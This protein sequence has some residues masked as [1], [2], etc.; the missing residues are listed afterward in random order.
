MRRE[1]EGGILYKALI[2][3]NDVRSIDN[4]YNAF[5]WK[6]LY[7]NEVIK[8]SNTCNLTQIIQKENP[9]IVMIDIEMGDVSG[10]DVIETCRKTGNKALFVIISGHCDFYCAKTAIKLDV[11]YFVS[12]PIMKWDVEEATIKIADKLHDMNHNPM[13]FLEMPDDVIHMSDEFSLFG[14]EK[15]DVFEKILKYIND[16]YYINISLEELGK[17][18]NVSI[19]YICKRFK[20]KLNTT[21]LEY[22]K[23]IRIIQ[24]KKMLINSALSITEIAERVGYKDYYYFNKVF[25]THTGYT[26]R[27]YKN[28]IGTARGKE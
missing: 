10:L 13:N 14:I 22:L 20:E 2:I 11:V 27:Q 15:E 19:S 7:V 5:E 6:K 23:R 12:K 25:K 28:M 24:A 1:K 21:F 26:P 17:C 8:I 16:F 18:F 9:D 3:D 4:I